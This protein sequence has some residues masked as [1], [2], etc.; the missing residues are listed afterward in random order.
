[1][2]AI[3]QKGIRELSALFEK[4]YPHR[5]NVLADNFQ[6]ITTG[7]ETKIF[8]FSIHFEAK[9]AAYSEDLI[10]R[11]Y[12]GPQG[13]AQSKREYAVIKKVA[14]AGLPVPKVVL[15]VSDSSP[16]EN[17]FVVMEKIDGPTMAAEL[18]H[19]SDKSK[20][21]LIK[22]FTAP[23]V[24]LHQLSWNQVFASKSQSLRNIDD[25][26]AYI[27]SKLSEMRTLIDRFGLTEFEGH[28]RWLEERLEHG[29]VSRLSVLHNDY[30]P[31][32]ILI[33][34]EEG[35]LA[36][37]DWSFA[38]VG[39]YRLDLAWSVLLLGVMAGEQYRDVM[40]ASYEQLSGDRVEHFQYFEVLKFTQRT[41]TI[42]T[43]LDDSVEIPV[44]KITKAA[45]HNDYKVHILNPYRRLKE[46]TGLSLNTIEAL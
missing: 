24:K 25:P 44:K 14:Q 17:P 12:Q 22:Q 32:N 30:H 38:E 18:D 41:L 29:A 45:I 16:F 34:D 43:W 33:R 20:R 1:M 26:L 9:G 2:V 35:G 13:T 8:S 27:N 6:E 28:F 7:W 19:A 31:L 46:I 4:K 39:D 10:L 42:A 3:T 37:I 21:S 40:L 15:L 23:F 11:F 36:I 5:K